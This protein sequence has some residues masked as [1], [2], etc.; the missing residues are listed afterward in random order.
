MYI[1]RIQSEAWKGA[2]CQSLVSRGGC[3]LTDDQAA[4]S[5]QDGLLRTMNALH[6]ADDI[7]SGVEVASHVVASSVAQNGGDELS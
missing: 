3:P 2:A 5:R 7:Y 6:E 4:D 1:G